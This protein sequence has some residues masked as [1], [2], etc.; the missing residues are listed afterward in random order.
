MPNP[1]LGLGFNSWSTKYSRGSAGGGGGDPSFDGFLQYTTTELSDSDTIT[2]RSSGFGTLDYDVNWGDG[3]T[4]NFTVHGTKT[5][6]YTT[7]GV[8]NIQVTLNAGHTGDYRI[9]TLNTNETKIA[10]VAGQG[11]S[12]LGLY[13]MQLAFRFY[14]NMTFMT[15]DF[16]VSGVQRLT[17][18]WYGCYV[19]AS[20]PALDFSNATFID[21]T[22]RS[23]RALTSFPLINFSTVTKCSGAWYDC[24]SLTSFPALN[25]GNVTNSTGFNSTWYGCSSLT[26]FPAVTMTNGVTFNGTWQNCTSLTTFPA[27]MFDTTGTLSSS[28]FN[29]SFNNCA[30]SAQSIENILTSLDTNGQ[31]GITLGI[32][33]GTNAAKTTWSAAA[34]NAYNNLITK[35][36]T[37]NYNA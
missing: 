17:D 35:S 20:F 36:W 2:I 19:L 21:N 11:G 7:G 8:Y 12:A 30:L 37:I 16:D 9:S 34:L 4:E 15:P 26:T 25:L 3:T 29:N 32:D 31:T 13:G 22:W 1:F 14:T 24:Q 27:N 6:T 18:A 23:C 33:G 5:H 28:A 10:A